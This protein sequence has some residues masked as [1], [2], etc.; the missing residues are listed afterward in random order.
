LDSAAPVSVL[1]ESIGVDIVSPDPNV[2]WRIGGSAVLR[3]TDGG[4]AWE[5]QSSGTPAELK[6]GAAPSAS[7]CWVVG[8]AGVV[9]LSTDGRTWRRVRFPEATDLSA[10][11]ASDAR[12]ASVSTADGR[13]FT[14]TDA[15][16]TWVAR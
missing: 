2:R 16:A 3:S 6:A 15:G 13:T 5:A 8:R 1:P 10:V 9:L 11:R 4:A 7:V 14:T 12:N